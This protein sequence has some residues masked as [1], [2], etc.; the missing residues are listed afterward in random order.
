M[1]KQQCHICHKS[2]YNLGRHS[3]TDK[4]IRKECDI[5]VDISLQAIWTASET[6]LPINPIPLTLN[7]F[8]IAPLIATLK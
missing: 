3:K 1:K 5:I 7:R 4:H 8:G 6:P 2:Y